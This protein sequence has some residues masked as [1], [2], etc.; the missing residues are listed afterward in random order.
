M[1]MAR[2]DH[3]D[4]SHPTPPVLMAMKTV[5]CK[6]NHDEIRFWS[7]YLNSGEG[8][9]IYDDDDDKG[10]AI[11]LLRPSFVIMGDQSV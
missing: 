4:W 10:L 9:Y 6:R 1:L 11:L 5:I 3:A 2:I 8:D 7:D